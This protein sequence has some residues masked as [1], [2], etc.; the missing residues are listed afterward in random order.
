MILKDLA[1]HQKKHPHLMQHSL[2]AMTTPT[3][4]LEAS[5]ANL[6]SSRVIIIRHANSTF[7]YR[8]ST[9]EREIA[10]KPHLGG[11]ERYLTVVKDRE[12]L[13]CPLSEFGVR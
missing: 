8:W 11:E 10:E 9:V 1:V 4:H 12:L 3:N 5:K 6:E 7:N 13:D 2:S